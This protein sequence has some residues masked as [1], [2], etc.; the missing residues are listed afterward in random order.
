[1][2]RL[3]A[4]L[5]LGALL[6]IVLLIAVG[7]TLLEALYTSLINILAWPYRFGSTLLT[8]WRERGEPSTWPDSGLD[9]AVHPYSGSTRSTSTRRGM[10]KWK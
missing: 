7:Q 3:R 9:R 2:N 4:W 10:Q 1:M 5:P 8:K 6:W